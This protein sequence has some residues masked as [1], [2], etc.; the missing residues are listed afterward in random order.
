MANIFSDKAG[1]TYTKSRNEVGK[2]Y[3]WV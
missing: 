1:K 3:S 2:D